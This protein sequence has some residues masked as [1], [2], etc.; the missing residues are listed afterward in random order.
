M[1]DLELDVNGKRYPLTVHNDGLF[2][3][4]VEDHPLSAT[5]FKELLSKARKVKVKF[6]LRFS[7][8][9]NGGV[10][11]GRVTGVHAT[12]RNY[13]C[14]WDDGQSEQLSTYGGGNQY[15]R[16]SD[17]E[18]AELER[19]VRNAK[20]AQQQLDAFRKGH[21]FIQGGFS[22]A[23]RDAQAKAAEAQS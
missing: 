8:E 4:M 2:Y 20:V 12:S 16:L 23:V 3:A 19:L 1:T 13:L 15:P 7:Q 11:H 9:H 18:S 21:A 22:A 6:E 10:R 14:R 5:T 17:D